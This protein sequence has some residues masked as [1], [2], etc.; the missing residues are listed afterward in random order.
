MPALRAVE[1]LDQGDEGVFERRLGPLRAADAVFQIVGRTL[2]DDVAAVDQADAVAV[3]GLVEE[4]RRHHDRDAVLDH[5]VDV[6]PELAPRQ[7]VHAGGRLVEEQH[8][9]VVHDR[10][11]QGQ[12]LL[13][14]QRQLAGVAIR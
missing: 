5:G 3:F 10:A 7:R 11:G 9:R 1:I 8:R 13:E 12:A 6:R 4:V 2:G 14:T